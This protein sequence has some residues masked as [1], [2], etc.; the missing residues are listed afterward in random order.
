MSGAA[1]EKML[2]GTVWNWCGFYKKAL[3]S[4]ADGSFEPGDYYG[5]LDEGIVSL[6]PFS[7]DVPAEVAALSN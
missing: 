6:A 4:V 3:A 2:T 5:G 1:D 7:K